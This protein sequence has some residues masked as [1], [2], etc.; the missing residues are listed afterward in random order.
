M[1]NLVW[2]SA[3]CGIDTPRNVSCDQGMVPTYAVVAESELDVSTAVKFA[4]NH[5]ITLVVKNT[6]HDL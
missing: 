6:G 2:E 3:G 1:Q 4:R 5:N